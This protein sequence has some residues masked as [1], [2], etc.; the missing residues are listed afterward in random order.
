MITSGLSELKMSSSSNGLL[1]ID[2]NYIP[3]KGSHSFHYVC[4][5]ISC[6]FIQDNSINVC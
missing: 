1:N 5:I 6:L 4:F 2:T 3:F